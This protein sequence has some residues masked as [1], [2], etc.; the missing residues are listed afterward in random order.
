MTIKSVH[1]YIAQAQVSESQRKLFVAQFIDDFTLHRDMK[2]IEK[3][4][5]NNDPISKLFE[6]IS[7]QLCIELK[8]K[9]PEWLEKP[10]LLKDPFFVSNMPSSRFLA[11]RD[12]P[13]AFRI[14]NIFVPYNYLSRV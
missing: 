7:H 8:L 3:P 10:V 2:C 5:L 14:R 12:S 6:A 1:E 11:L 9:T 13:I 4:I